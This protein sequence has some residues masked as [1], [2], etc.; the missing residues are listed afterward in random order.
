[1]W[2][3]YSVK[4]EI[5]EKLI[6][7]STDNKR[8]IEITVFVINLF[9]KTIAIYYLLTI[10]HVIVDLNPSCSTSQFNITPFPTITSNV[11][12]LPTFGGAGKLK[13]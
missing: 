7:F 2:E 3:N 6:F 9:A 11:S 4:T 8:V 13:W 12:S 10:S 5:S 1:M